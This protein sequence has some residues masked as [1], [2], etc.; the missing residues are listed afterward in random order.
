[1]ALLSAAGATLAFPMI[2][3]MIADAGSAG[4]IILMQQGFMVLLV[5][6]VLLGVTSAFRFYMVSWLG[7]RVV[8]DIRKKLFDHFKTTQCILRPEPNR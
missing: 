3:R 5:C 7:E 4:N 6:A 2:I 1:M 8:S